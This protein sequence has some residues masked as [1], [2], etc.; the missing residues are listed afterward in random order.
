VW[1][2]VWSLRM[3]SKLSFVKSV[4]G[5]GFDEKHVQSEKQKVYMVLF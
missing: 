1:N 5:E 4:T 3:N 2:F